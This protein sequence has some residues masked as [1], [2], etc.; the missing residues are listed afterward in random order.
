MNLE[1]SR[2][3]HTIT[4]YIYST[5]VLCWSHYMLFTVS[6]RFESCDILFLW[7]PGKNLTAFLVFKFLF[8]LLLY[9]S[10]IPCKTSELD[11]FDFL[12]GRSMAC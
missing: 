6:F 4:M 11:Y 7:N 10:L 5:L 2:I 9:V 8:A 3:T 12:P 1:V